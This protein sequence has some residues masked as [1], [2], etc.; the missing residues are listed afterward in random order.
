[1]AVKPAPYVAGDSVSE[2]ITDFDGTRNVEV[3]I[4]VADADIAI[5]N[6]S[7]SI[8][9]SRSLTKVDGDA[10]R[11]AGLL[12]EFLTRRSAGMCGRVYRLSWFKAG[13]TLWHNVIV[14]A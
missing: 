4:I 3:M 10:E 13:P 1:L 8:D 11:P 7:A 6:V 5:E 9:N 14:V 2:K 12:F